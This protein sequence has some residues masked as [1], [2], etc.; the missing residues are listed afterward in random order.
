MRCRCGYQQHLHDLNLPP[1]FW[2]E[3]V[4]M[5]VYPQN[6][7]QNR[8]LTMA[9]EGVMSNEHFYGMQPEGGSIHTFER[10]VRGKSPSEELD[11]QGTWAIWGRTTTEA[12]ITSARSP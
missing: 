7:T 6:R 11:D 3:V 4:T 8:T 12:V 1:C 2:A 5:L 9:N 10:I